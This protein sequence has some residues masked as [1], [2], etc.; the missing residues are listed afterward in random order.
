MNTDKIGV[1]FELER[2]AEIVRLC[3]KS[4]RYSGDLQAIWYCAA[5]FIHLNQYKEAITEIEKGLQEWPDN[6]AF[7]QLLAVAF[8][9]IGFYEKAA[10]SCKIILRNA[11]LS[12]AGN[13]LI[14]HIFIQQDKYV[15]AAAHLQQVLDVAPEDIDAHLL[16]AHVYFYTDQKERAEKS[17]ARVLEYDPKNPDALGFLA[18]LAKNSVDT[19]GLLKKALLHAPTDK[20]L[21]KRYRRETKDKKLAVLFAILFSTLL[22]GYSAYAPAT[23]QEAG[24][25]IVRI[26]IV[27]ALIYFSRF[28]LLSA[29]LSFSV[30]TCVA[31]MDGELFQSGWTSTGAVSKTFSELAAYAIMACLAVLI[32]L[33]IRTVLAIPLLWLQEKWELYSRQRK[34]GQPQE[35]LGGKIRSRQT[36]FFIIGS[37][38]VPLA[39]C[40][41]HFSPSPE[42][43]WIIFMLSFFVVA[44]ALFFLADI[45]SILVIVQST[46]LYSLCAIGLTIFWASLMDNRA[47]LVIPFVFAACLTGTLLAFRYGIDKQETIALQNTDTHTGGMHHV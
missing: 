18:A 29:L 9:S 43:F 3:K 16:L 14:A 40:T 12:L 22:I 39:N 24:S 30:A 1:L 37:F 26:L 8:N 19:A 17:V 27:S 25:P 35:P 4:S 36:W 10:K 15:D 45:K 11:P 28:F 13:L 38:L 23:I 33:F 5:S 42:T 20:E 41:G 7:H 47:F 32:A 21:Q 34:A 44:G 46:L 2:Y 6:P 31:F